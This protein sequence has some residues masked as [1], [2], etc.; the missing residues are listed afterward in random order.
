MSSSRSSRLGVLGVLVISS[1]YATGMIRTTL[2]AVPRRITMLTS[3]V[4][5]FAVVA[6]VSALVASFAAFGIGQS[7]FASKGAGVSLSDGDVLRAVLGAAVYLT[8]VGL[9]GVALGTILRRT[10]GAIATLFGLVL[11]LPALTSA[12]PSPWDNNVGKFTPS[13]LGTS[14]FTVHPKNDLLSPGAAAAMMAVYV[15][16]ALVIA[17]VVLQRRDA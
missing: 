6:A 13:G 9:L 5:V 2:T 7:I 4:L 8:G 15:V 16:V 12:L 14:L 1:E 10:A 3:K 17:A 11:V